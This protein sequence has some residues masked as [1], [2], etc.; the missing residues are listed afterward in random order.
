M[1]VS[2]N[3]QKRDFFVYQ[4]RVDDYP[5]YVGIGRSARAS[6]RLRYVKSLM[7]PKH[8][9]TLAKKSLSVRVMAALLRRKIDIRLSCTRRPMNRRQALEH[10]REV[11]ARLVARGFLLTN[12]QHNPCRHNDHRKALKAIL[13]DP[14]VKQAGY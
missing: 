10:E 8:A 7:I 5:F 9:S 14:K 2:T 6:D 13:S 12:W 4:F 1:P 3:A 11:I